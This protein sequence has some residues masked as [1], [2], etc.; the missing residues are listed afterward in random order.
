MTTRFKLRRVVVTASVIVTALFGATV[1]AAT[2]AQIDTAWNKGLAW[3]IKNQNGD[4]S[5]GAEKGVG[6]L[7]TTAGLAALHKAQLKSF[8]YAKAV[9]WVGNTTPYSTDS[10]ARKIEAKALVGLDVSADWQR[11]APGNGSWGAYPGYSKSYPDNALAINAYLQSGV[12]SSEGSWYC[13]FL[14]DQWTGTGNPALDGSW[15][16]TP[17]QS[18]KGAILPTMASILAVN[19]IKNALQTGT[20]SWCNT[21]GHETAGDLNAAMNNGINWLVTQKRNADGGFGEEGTSNVFSTVLAYEVLSAHR[22]ND[23]ATQ[24]ALDYLLATQAANG[25]WNNDGMMSAYALKVLPAPLVVPMADS[26]KD[27]LPDTVEPYLGLN[28]LLADSRNIA[29]SNGSSIVQ[30]GGFVVSLAPLKFVSIDLAAEGGVPPYSWSIVAGGLPYDLVFDPS[31]KIMGV[32]GSSWVTR[33][34][35]FKVVDQR[36]SSAL[37]QAILQVTTNNSARGVDSDGD[38]ISDAWEWMYAFNPLVSG[39][40]QLDPDGDGVSNVAEYNAGTSPLSSDSD[41]DG[42]K[43]GC[44]VKYN[45]AGLQVSATRSDLVTI[46]YVGTI[47]D[48]LLLND[49]LLSSQQCV[50][51]AIPFL[52]RCNGRAYWDV[53][54]DGLDTVAECKAGTE[55]FKADTDGDGM[56]DGPEVTV[57]RNPLVNEA[58]ILQIINSILMSDEQPKILPISIL[59]LILE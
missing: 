22:P 48:P 47:T 43:D 10:L 56:N 6:M 29:P 58:V 12:G 31:G 51:V 26:D 7:G 36:G 57:G 13:Y 23:A 16:Y 5:W 45:A 3:L 27:G 46:D 53:D 14:Y 39:D 24:G 59:N 44:E 50:N 4:G 33:S 1:H 15:T 49:S 30:A 52:Y 18:T 40:A 25:S 11:L 55:L 20:L 41:L 42:I 21:Q 38:G 9:A 17:G 54:H 35:T 19:R 2:Q 8:S 37:A 32:P 28:P 34:I